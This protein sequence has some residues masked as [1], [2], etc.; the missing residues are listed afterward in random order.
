MIGLQEAFDTIV[1]GALVRESDWEFCTSAGATFGV[2][3]PLIK[4]GVNATGGSFWVKKRFASDEDR[5]RLDFGG[6]GGQAGLSAVPSPI[7]FSFSVP[8]FWSRGLIYKF[9]FAG[10]SLSFEEM[11]G[12]FLMIEVSRDVSVGGNAAVM[13]IGGNQVAA[14][15]A[16]LSAG[17]G[18]Q[19]A[20]LITTSKACVAFAGHSQTIVPG[21]IGITM[22][23]GV[24][25]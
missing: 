17:T 22:Y 20:T 25:F 2:N 7:N 15:A 18:G 1:S 9:P 13:F 4:L 23:A 21:N 10:W 12:G 3:T 11:K 6:A 8:D 24:T 16:G 14:A 5:L 19:L